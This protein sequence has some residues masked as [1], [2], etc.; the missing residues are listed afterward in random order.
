MFLL[1]AEF[2]LG[3]FDLLLDLLEVSD[4]EEVGLLQRVEDAGELLRLFEVHLLLFRFIGELLVASR[5]AVGVE[6]VESLN[7]LLSFLPL[8]FC[9]LRTQAL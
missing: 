3:L 4:K 9:E 5:V 6:A 7:L 2:V 1:V 8:F